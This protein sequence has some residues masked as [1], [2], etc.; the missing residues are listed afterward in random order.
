MKNEEKGGRRKFKYSRFEICD[1]VM[2]EKKSMEQLALTV[3]FWV[4]RCAQQ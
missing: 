4:D 3:N 1:V 2:V